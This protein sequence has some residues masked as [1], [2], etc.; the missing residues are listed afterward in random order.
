MR[1]TTND[2][3]VALDKNQSLQIIQYAI[4]HLEIFFA[5]FLSSTFD[6]LYRDYSM[7]TI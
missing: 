4:M 5:S 7:T 1:R 2:T 6:M 3:E